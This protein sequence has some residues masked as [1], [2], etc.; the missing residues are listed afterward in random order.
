MALHINQR[1]FVGIILLICV[2]S[3]PIGLMGRNAGYNH[4]NTSADFDTD[5]FTMKFKDRI[6]VIRLSGIIA[7]KPES[8]IFTMGET[9]TNALKQLRK[10]VKDKHVKGILL[11]INSPGGTVPASQEISDEVLSLKG[12]GKPIVA[13]MADLAASGGYY[14]AAQ[15]DKIVAEPGTL[16]GSI[17]VIFSTIN[18]KG[19]GTKLGL[20][21]EVVK[22]GQFKDIGSPYRPM[23]KEDRAILQTLIFD[24]YDQFVSA[25][26]HGRKMP[27]EIVKKLADG[28]VYSGRQAV[29]LGLVDQLGGYDKSLAL[30]QET[31]KKQYQNKE[32]FP[33]EDTSK[34]SFL[35]ELIESSNDFVHLFSSKPV[36]SPQE[37]LEAFIPEF[38]QAKFHHQ[39]LWIMP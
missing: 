7:D 12:E 36:Q 10:A 13:S 32:D 33:V 9:S 34:A 17:G 16:T 21:P 37:I 14:I 27:I 20:E 8:S 39:L 15:A 2:V 26:A 24:S 35:A 19:L 31:C 18:L 5:A 38:M 4:E 23:T 28:R 22:S 6:Q 30:L 11:R 25:V 3:I 1:W 29:K